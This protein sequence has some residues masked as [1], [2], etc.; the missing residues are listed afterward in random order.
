[1]EMSEERDTAM[2]IKTDQ[3]KRS[4]LNN[5]RWKNKMNRASGNAEQYKKLAICITRV[6]E[7]KKEKV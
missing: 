2:K 6:P 4:N 7:G 1:M 5:R 3:Y